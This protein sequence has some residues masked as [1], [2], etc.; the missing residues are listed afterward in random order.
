MT[1]MHYILTV[2][3]ETIP[4]VVQFARDPEFLAQACQS[5]HL[6]WRT[7]RITP[8]SFLFAA[9]VQQRPKMLHY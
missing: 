3:T 9:Q 8:Q 2:S 6:E 4:E 7:F 1:H 5:G